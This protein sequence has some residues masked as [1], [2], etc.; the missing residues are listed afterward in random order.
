MYTGMIFIKNGSPDSLSHHGILG[1]KWGIRRY[2]NKDGTLTEAG[3]KREAKLRR[4]LAKYNS[5]RTTQ[6]FKRATVRAK[7]ESE[8]L[9]AKSQASRAGLRDEYQRR[10]IENEKAKSDSDLKTHEARNKY[11]ARKAEV[12]A[13]NYEKEREIAVKKSEEDLKAAQLRN[14]ELSESWVKKTMKATIAGLATAAASTAGK[15]IVENWFGKDKDDDKDDG[16]DG[17]GKGKEEKANENQQ[18]DKN[19]GNNKGDSKPEP[20]DDNKKIKEDYEKLKMKAALDKSVVEKSL[21][22]LDNYFKNMYGK[23]PDDMIKTDSETTIS[24]LYKYIHDSNKG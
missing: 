19:K 9:D 24:A 6:E 20:S 2:Q 16:K 21:S 7:A 15:K 14:K 11:E 1:M 22:D 5:P 4:E 10:V 18:K 17:K 12:D 13:K 23:T 8:Y 3:K